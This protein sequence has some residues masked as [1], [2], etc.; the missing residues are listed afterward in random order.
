MK[1]NI[2]SNPKPIYFISTGLC[3][4]LDPPGFCCYFKPNP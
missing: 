2:S 1:A 4:T 3:L